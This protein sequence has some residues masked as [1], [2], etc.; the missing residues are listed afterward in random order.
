MKINSLNSINRLVVVTEKLRVL[1]EVGIALLYIYIKV[2]LR[3]VNG[4]Q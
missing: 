1:Y 3:R 4:F 2:V